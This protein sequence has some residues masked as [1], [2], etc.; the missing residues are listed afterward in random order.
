[1]QQ[2]H[3]KS[4]GKG[5]TEQRSRSGS[6]PVRGLSKQQ[7]AQKQNP[8]PTAGQKQGAAKTPKRQGGGGPALQKDPIKHLI[9]NFLKKTDTFLTSFDRDRNKM[10]QSHNQE[11]VKL[12]MWLERAPGWLHRVEED[13][14]IDDIRDLL[15][16]YNLNNLFDECIKLDKQISDADQDQVSKYESM[17]KQYKDRIKAL[18]DTMDNE[19]LMQLLRY[20][21]GKKWSFPNFQ[22]QGEADSNVVNVPEDLKVYFTRDPS[23]KHGHLNER[24]IVN[25]NDIKDQITVGG[26]PYNITKTRDKITFSSEDQP[27]ISTHKCMR[28]PNDYLSLADFCRLLRTPIHFPRSD[29]PFVWT[30]LTNCVNDRFLENVRFMV[31]LTSTFLYH[32]PSCY[33]LNAMDDTTR[34]DRKGTIINSF[35]ELV[36]WFTT[37]DR[38]KYRLAFVCP[39]IR[40]SRTILPSVD[41][42]TIAVYTDKDGVKTISLPIFKINVLD[43]KELMYIN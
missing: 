35:E 41:E 21:T 9:S 25:R 38:T 23:R 11:V 15:R 31:N 7:Q 30:R 37:T 28:D 32:L 18:K 39:T 10:T 42:K 14:D 1:V 5:P 3:R 17:Y 4:A 16:T 26:H 34:R 6:S 13:D 22:Q 12:M 43:Y 24:Y 20:N 19:Q 36:Q 8:S 27:T 2:Q 33:K 40:K 29:E